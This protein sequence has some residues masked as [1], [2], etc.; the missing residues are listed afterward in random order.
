MNQK[1]LLTITSL[2]SVLLLAFHLT[3]D[4]VR[5]F[6]RGGTLTYVGVL[7]MAAWVYATLVLVEQR[8]GYIVILLASLLGA[9]VPYIHMT[10]AGMVGGR[11]AHDAG[12][13]A[14]RK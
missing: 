10:G 2:L 7:I 14:A 11:I 3:E 1:V 6:E 8:S 13:V 12:P 5:G 4:I 9:Y